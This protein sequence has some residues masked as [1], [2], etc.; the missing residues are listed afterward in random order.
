MP[1]FTVLELA[2]TITALENYI[3]HLSSFP[4]KDS[5]IKLK[6]EIEIAKTSLNK[7][8]KEYQNSFGNFITSS[9]LLIFI[10]DY[11]IITF[12]KRGDYI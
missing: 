6:G 3:N 12:R 4:N 2:V 11:V 8:M 7:A 5:D 10:F 1:D 9:A